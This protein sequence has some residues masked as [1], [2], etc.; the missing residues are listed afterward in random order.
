MI[1]TASELKAKVGRYLDT[2][3]REDVFVTRKGKV[4]AKISNPASD[5]LA[6]LDSLAGIAE[7][8]HLTAREARSERLA[9]K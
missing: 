4:V 6:I 5:K 9:G 8:V 3:G 7:G 1:I 2:A